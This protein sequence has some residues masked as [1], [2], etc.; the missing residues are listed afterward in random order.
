MLI[1]TLTVFE[2]DAVRNFYLAVSTDDH[3]KRFCCTLSDE[4]IS[5]YV[6]RLDFKSTALRER[7]SAAILDP[8]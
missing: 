6:G 3:R 1:R 5:R 8:C 7:F 2:R 4:T